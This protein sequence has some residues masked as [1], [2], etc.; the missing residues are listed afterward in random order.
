MILGLVRH[1]KVNQKIN[2]VF[3]SPVEFGQVMKEYDFCPIIENDLIIDSNYWDVCYC[4]S[5]PRA[6]TTAKT[7]Y[8][9]EIIK[10]DLLVEVPILPFT[11]IKIKLPSFVWHIGARIAWYMSHNSQ[12]EDVHATRERVHKFYNLIL[13]SE[14]NRILIVAHG[15]FLRMLYEE[16]KKKNFRGHIDLNIANGKL[17]VFEN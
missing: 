12:P 2:N 9:G 13:N 17:Y 6:I 3:L 16:M 15:Y 5:L 4:S 8:D 14:K 7:I 11:K 1:F 10:S